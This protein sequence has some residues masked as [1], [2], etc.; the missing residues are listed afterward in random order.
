MKERG[1][2]RMCKHRVVVWDKSAVRSV[3]FILLVFWQISPSPLFVIPKNAAI[4]PDF[5]TEVFFPRGLRGFRNPDFE[6]EPG[7]GALRSAPG[8]GAQ[9]VPAP[10]TLV[11]KG[12]RSANS[13]EG[14]LF[15]DVVG[16]ETRQKWR[17]YRDGGVCG[18]R[19]SQLRLE[20]ELIEPS[21]VPQRRVRV[22]Q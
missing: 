19:I 7:S 18:V 5:L 21:P 12:P 9:R 6:P 22:R 8:S 16:Y 3:S 10:P 14:E 13:N 4:F 15:F 2:P 11:V 17:K 20:L 1:I